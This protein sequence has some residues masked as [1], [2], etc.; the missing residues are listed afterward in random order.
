MENKYNEI[1]RLNKLKENGTI[2]ETEFEI[3]KYKI[4]NSTSNT[5]QTKKSKLFFILSSISIGIS[6][7]FGVISYCWHDSDMYIDTLL[8]NKS[9]NNDIS[10]IVN[11]SFT[12]LIITTIIMLVIGIIFK[13]KEK[14][15]IKI[16]H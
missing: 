7:I 1:E 4:L 13:I 6:I 14:G 16:V 9:L 12:I 3:Q 8:N 10:S 11:G 5:T 2:T 15:G